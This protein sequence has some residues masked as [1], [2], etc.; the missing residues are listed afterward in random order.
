M[1]MKILQTKNQS[2]VGEAKQGVLDKEKKKKRRLVEKEEKKNETKR[3]ERKPERTE[4]S[5]QR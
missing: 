2:A 3:N 4:R 5:Q 1:D